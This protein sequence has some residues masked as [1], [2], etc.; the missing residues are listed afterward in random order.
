MSLKAFHIAFIIVSTVLAIGFG[1]W[2]L[3]GYATS[4]DVLQ[5]TAGIGS[6]LAAA[7]L[8]VYGVRFMRKLKHVS[9]I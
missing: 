8:V 2:E 5:L 9:M 1:I 7:G 3:K 4:D 6:L